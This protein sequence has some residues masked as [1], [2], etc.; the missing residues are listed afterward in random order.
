M[1]Q[2]QISA[3]EL[4]E[5][6]KN[7]IASEEEFLR[8]E[9]EKDANNQRKNRPVIVITYVMVAVFM[10]LVVYVIYFMQ[11]K[12]ET[13]IAN[14]RNVR[15]DTF[16]DRVIR[17]NVVTSDGEIIAETVIDEEGKETRHYPYGSMFAHAV[18]YDT[19]GRSG[20]E[21]SG[22]FYMLRSHTNIVEKV[23]R[24]LKDEKQRGDNIITTLDKRLQ[25]TAYNALGYANGA[26]V[27]IEPSTGRILCMVSKPDFDPNDIDNVWEY[28]H[29]DEGAKTSV[30]LNRATQGLYA[31]GSTFKVVTLLAYLREHPSDADEY[32]YTCYGEDDY[33]NV[34]IS[35]AGGYAHGDVSLES[36]L[37]YS[38]NT[39]FANI[40]MTLDKAGYKK[41]AEDFLINKDLPYDGEY[42]KSSFEIDAGSRDVEIPQTAIGQGDTR[43]TP[44]QNAIIMCSIANGGE[45]MRPYLIDGIESANG[46]KIKTMKPKSAG[47]LI[48]PAEARKLT[49]YMKSVCDY[50]TASWYFSDTAYDVTGKTGTAEYGT[51]GNTNS[52]FAGFSNPDHPDLVVSVIVEDENLNGINATGV[53]KQLFDTYYAE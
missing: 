27:A 21:L 44:L 7:K 52:W 29:T 3:D 33:A 23:T 11:M 4:A 46:T 8:R 20:L 16:S 18:G 14:T 40:G 13:T 9:E 5:K 19:H 6:L 38:C 45:L 26:V 22:N 12:A 48:Q 25:E 53:A 1:Q 15:Q 43:I 51:E 47:S 30:L 32:A 37:A 36:S 50:G 42:N 24:G 41:T 10:C 39:S 2:S 35:C 34:E 49:D 28:L 31:P 17:G